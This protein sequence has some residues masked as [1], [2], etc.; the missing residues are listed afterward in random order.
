VH[1]SDKSIPHGLLH[2]IFGCT[3]ECEAVDNRADH[4]TAPHELT[5]GVADVAVAPA[6]PVNPA[7][8]QRVAA[9]QDVE[10]PVQSILV[11]R[12]PMRV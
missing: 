6:Q 3:V 8:D 2:W 12:F 1:E 5:N 11:F 10:Q 9:P 7:H 4:N